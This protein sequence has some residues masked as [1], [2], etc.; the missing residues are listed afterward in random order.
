MLK[1]QQEKALEN[2]RNA[3]PEPKMEIPVK[4]DRVE[5]I[6]KGFKLDLDNIQKEGQLGFHEEFY[7][8]L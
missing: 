4:K 1:L 8:K 2:S 6:G 7:S 5:H 3:I